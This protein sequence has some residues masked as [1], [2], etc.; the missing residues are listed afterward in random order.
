MQGPVGGGGLVVRYD[1]PYGLGEHGMYSA[2]GL[3]SVDSK[4]IIVE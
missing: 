1:F 3:V 2:D 4:G